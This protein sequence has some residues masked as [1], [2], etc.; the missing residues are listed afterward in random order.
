MEQVAEYQECLAT[1][2]T[3]AWI[4]TSQPAE[5]E[6]QYRVASFMGAWIETALPWKQVP[7]YRS[8]TLHG[9]VD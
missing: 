5:G 2:F 6:A 3:G 7:G 1:P 4:E 9:C 8:R